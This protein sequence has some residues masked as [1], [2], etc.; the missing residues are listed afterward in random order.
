MA[1]DLVKY[2]NYLDFSSRHIHIYY[3]YDILKSISPNAIARGR[4]TFIKML[5]WTLFF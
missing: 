1:Y 3:L 4:K 5:I 2:I